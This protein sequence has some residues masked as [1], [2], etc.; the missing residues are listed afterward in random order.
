MK[1]K[2]WS[3]F[4]ESISGWELIGK[5]MGPNY[6]EQNLPNSISSTDT[7][8]LMD[9]NGQYYTE[10]DFIKYLYP[11]YLSKCP[12]NPLSGFNQENLDLVIRT[13]ST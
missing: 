1:I 10:D 3:D 9:F 6:P 8:I 7:T 12:S 5:H 2:K 11:E 13:L 4:K